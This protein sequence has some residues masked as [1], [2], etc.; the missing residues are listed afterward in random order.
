M[1]EIKDKVKEQKR[2]ISLTS[3]M[4]LV[5]SNQTLTKWN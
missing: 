2:Y 1:S 4:K 5:F 3:R